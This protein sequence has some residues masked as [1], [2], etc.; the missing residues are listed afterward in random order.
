MFNGR[1]DP[2]LEDVETTL[3]L[4]VLD[5]FELNVDDGTGFEV[6]QTIMR[7]RKQTLEGDFGEVQEMQRKWDE[8]DNV[9]RIEFQVVANDDN[10][11]DWDSDDVESSGE[12]VEM[13]EA[14]I[15]KPKLDKVNAEV[16]EDGF[17]KVVGKKKR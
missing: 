4:A 15:E 16:D 14:P 6:A 7:I 8:K 17:T 1:R 11:T 2:D 9:E 13:A 12:D 10:D 5:E 3:L